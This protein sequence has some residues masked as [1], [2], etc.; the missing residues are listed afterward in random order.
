MKYCNECGEKLILK[1]DKNEG[2]VHYCKNC[3]QFKYEMFNSAISAI[4]FN[5]TKDKILLISQY[6]RKSRILVAGYINKGENAKEALIREIKEE[7][8]LNV[9]HFTY[10][11]NEYYKPTNTLMHNYAVIVDKEEFI[12]NEEVDK[13][14]WYPIDEAIKNI[15]P[16]SL[17]QA[18]L[19]K[20]IDKIAPK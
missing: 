1:Q 20:Y 17:A 18:F 14:R 11:D 7:T 16:N 3:Q 5:P 13:A 10:N 8:N 12:L 2:L 9:V 19:M 15:K 4:I 6:G